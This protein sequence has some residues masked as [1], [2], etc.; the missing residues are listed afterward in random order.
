MRN[1]KGIT[2]VSLVIYI[3]VVMVVAAVVI[4][5]TTYF[6]NSMTDVANVDFETEFQKINLYLLDESKTIGNGIDEII[7]DT[8]IVFT[9]GNKYEYNSSEKII[10][11]NETIKL[12]EK[13]DS[14]IFSEKTAENGKNVITLTIKIGENS[15]TVDYVMQNVELQNV[16]VDI[17]DYLIGASRVT[18]YLKAGD[19]IDYT[20][21]IGIY[22]VVDGQY[23]S[24]YT[25]EQGYQSFKT[26]TGENALRWR[27]LSIDE[28]TGKINIVSETVAQ[29]ATPL[30]LKG[31][32]GYN[33]AVDIL[34]DLCKTLY[35]KTVEGKKI[36]TAR[37]INIEDIDAKTTFEYQNYK[38][39]NEGLTYGDKKQLSTYGINFMNYPN[40]YTK[41]MAYGTA[42]NFNITG[43]KGSEGLKDGVID[44]NG[45]TTY[46]TVIGSTNGNT[47]GT[48]PYAT[49]T[50]YYYRA[51]NYL[52]TNLGINKVPRGLLNVGKDYWLASRYSRGTSVYI[53]YGIRTIDYIGFVYGKVVFNNQGSIYS[54]SQSIRPVVT[55]DATQLLD[56]STGNGSKENPWKMK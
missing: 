43:L 52:N 40:L 16:E 47:A 20:P 49:Y 34:N 13:V 17:D 44:A 12:C 50:Y 32:D 31:A 21:D 41:E 29:E 51:E 56:F 5:I 54:N 48:N 27:I 28:Q 8:K 42:G 45:L 14:C 55:L 18:Y 23:G 26:E 7:S 2:L 25:T 4:R 35:S 46:S 9:N 30:Y 39:D 6:K 19:Y 24:G 37:S 10:Y 3:A 33:H 36:A 38:D 15:K 22:K 11:L 1:K 53:F